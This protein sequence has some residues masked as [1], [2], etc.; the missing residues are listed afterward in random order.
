VKLIHSLD[1]VDLCSVLG[2][3][4]SSSALLRPREMQNRDNEEAV[5]G[6]GDTG[7]GIIPG[8]EGC[9]DAESTSGSCQA[10]VRLAVLEDQIGATEE[11]EGKVEGEEQQEEGDC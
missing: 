10:G 9:D 11:E 7:E 3:G 8:Q 5:R 4:A 2:L 1:K 6:V